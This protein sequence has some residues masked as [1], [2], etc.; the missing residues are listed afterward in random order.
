[1]HTGARLAQRLLVIVS[2]LSASADATRAQETAPPQDVKDT[3]PATP[4]PAPVVVVSQPGA[5]SGG[6]DD[7]AGRVQHW[8]DPDRNGFY[9]WVGSIMPGGWLAGGGGYRHELVRGIKVDALAGISLRNYKLLDAGLTV[10]VTSD[11]RVLVEVR[12]RLMDAPRVHFYGLGNESSHDVETRF[13]YEPKR[14]DARLRLRPTSQ[15]EIGA[16]VGLLHVGTG[17]GSVGPPITDVFTPAE[18]PGLLQSAS[19][20]TMA[21]YAQA[22]RRDTRVFTRAGGW[23]RADWQL[24]ADGDTRAF[25]HQRVDLDVRQFFPIVDERHAVLARGVFTG[26]RASGTDLVP[27]FMMPTLGDGENLRGFANQRFTDR[28]RLLLQGEYRYRIND[29]LHA[30]GFVDL[31][32]VAPRLGD[33]SFADLH[34]GYG[35]GLRMQT[36]EGLSIRTDI[37]RSSEQWSIIV[38]SVIF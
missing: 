23:Y 6:L 15:A 22:D 24:F 27:H 10:P 29:R 26:T 33:L 19:Y 14:I 7:I 35:V 3:A 2:L 9:P 1:M 30:A 17:L 8:F 20:R 5:S 4:P 31:G 32:R 12:T 37:A 16:S 28:H 18:V 34:P 21:L 25:G 38:S 36:A 13:D 11:D